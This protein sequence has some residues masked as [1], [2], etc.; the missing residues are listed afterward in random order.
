MDTNLSRVGV[1][2]APIHRDSLLG[3]R[4]NTVRTAAFFD[5]SWEMKSE[6]NQDPSAP[7]GARR[8]Y[9]PRIYSPNILRRS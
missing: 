4:A 3:R 8:T 2:R 6:G 9:W 1:S 7:H 5:H